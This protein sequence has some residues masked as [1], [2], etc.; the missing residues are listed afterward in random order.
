MSADTP[1][2]RTSDIDSA[3]DANFDTGLRLG[4]AAGL[5]SSGFERNRY[6]VF[7]WEENPSPEEYYGLYLRNPYAYAAVAQK[8]D[9]TWRDPPEI[10]DGSHPEDVEPADDGLTDFERAVRKLATATDAWS[11]ASRADRLAGIGTHGV[12]VLDLDDTDGPEDF[13]DS[14]SPAGG[15]GLDHLRG[16]RV[17]SQVSIHDIEYGDPGTDRWGKPETYYIDLDE[18]PVDEESK[19]SSGD[20]LEV[21]HRRVIDVPSRPP[22]DDEVHARPRIE[23]VLNVVYDIEKT[24]GAAAELAYAGAKQDVHINFDPEKVNTDKVQDNDDE[25]QNWYHNRQPWIRTTG[26]EVEQVTDATTVDPSPTIDSELRAFSAATDIPQQMLDGSA[27][28]EIAGAEQNERDYFGTISERREQF[29]EPHIVRAL[30]DRLESLGVLPSPVGGEG[31]GRDYRIEWPD[32]TELSEADVSELRNQR[33]QIVK[34]LSAVVP[35]LSGER[36]EQF[37]ESGEFPER[38]EVEIE[39]MDMAEERRRMQEQDQQPPE[40]SPGQQ[41]AMP[42]GGEDES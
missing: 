2:S 6:D 33:A 18:D 37:V 4:L 30:I 19:P 40:Q 41:P 7:G 13:A 39:P 20:I 17:Y 16:F 1:P 29:A 23:L 38:D 31:Y 34:R 11:Y 32:L 42:D 35:E 14:P 36:A 9:T 21:D 24:L 15:S 5:G 27:A 25:L 3:R 10:V 12:L 8:A 26:G 28:G 22:D